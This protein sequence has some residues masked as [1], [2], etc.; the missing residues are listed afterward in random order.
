M[1]RRRILIT[2]LIIS[3]LAGCGQADKKDA[4][5]EDQLTNDEIRRISRD[6]YIYAFPIIDNLRIQYSYFA[7]KNDPE[8]K[9]PYNVLFN[10][11][12]VFTPK[13]RVIQTPNSDTPYSWAGL[14]L[15]TE[16]VIFII[17]KIDSSRYWSLQLI[18]L[19]THNFD[20]LGSRT[21]GNDGGVFMITG[22]NW[23]G[24][25]PTG[26]TKLIRCETE[27]AMALIRTQLF[28]PKDLDNVKKVQSGYK[29]LTLSSFLG[30]DQAQ[31]T[32]NT[33]FPKPLTPEQQ[34]TSLAMFEHLNFA[35]NFCPTHTSE[36]V[37]MEEFKKIGIDRG[38]KF[39]TATIAP[40]TLSAM[41]MGIADA[42]RGHD[43]I[44]QLLNQGKLS[45]SDGFGTRE[46]LNNN[47]LLRMAS[48]AGGIYGNS[49]EE[50]MYPVYYVDNKGQLLN[51]QS[52]YQLKFAP[53]QLPPVNAFWSLTMYD[54]LNLLVDNPIN[55]YLL[56]STMLK[57]L[58]KEKDGTITL[59]IQ[60]QS[61]GKNL[62]SNWL[63]APAG[64]FRMI[65]RLYWPKEE[66]LNGRW[67][68]PPVVRT[69]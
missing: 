23:K 50:A 3:I 2:A 38:K 20:Y 19:Y 44:I 65:M 60:N 37:L 27:I 40:E 34:R 11:P 31:P 68:N 45:S 57:Q 69:S 56:N 52:K 67:K 18:D 33:E 54:S 13:D 64:L 32:A 49:K 15:R 7:D 1:N 29:L 9:A 6:A 10:I 12:R 66:A 8:Y 46:F 59:Y 21:T 51:G 30:E 43:S 53:G 61:P 42:W 24:E 25:T 26:V 14:D 5:E 62:E 58:K 28:N 36:T 39:D 41:R 47:Y 35:L 63:P 22:P 17:P 48:A 4:V 55:R 16:P